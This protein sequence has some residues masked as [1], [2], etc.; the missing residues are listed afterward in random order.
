MTSLSRN[1]FVRAAA[2]SAAVFASIGILRFPADAAEFTLKF[3]C[4]LAPDHPT[5]VGARDVATK[6]RTQTNGR[7][8]IQVF[9]AN[10]L[11]N[12]QQMLSQLRAGAMQL[13]AIGDNI[14]ATLVP[15]AAINN[16]GFTWSNA[17][18]A[19]K[20]LDGDLGAYVRG[21]IERAGLHPMTKVWDEGFREMTSATKPLRGPDD[22]QGFKMR[23]PPSPISTSLFKA[24]GASPT[25]I[26]VK[27]LYSA[28]ETHIVDG[29]ENSLSVI[30]TQKLFEVQK[31]CSLT[32]HM[33][34]AYWIV[35]NPDALGKLPKDLQGIVSA[36]FDDGASKQRVEN[37]REDATLRSKLES[38]GLKFID[39]DRNA[40]RQTL[41]KAG[42][43]KQM[44]EEFGDKPWS[45]LQ[46]YTDV[47]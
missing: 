7:V 22:L 9:P 42:F 27:D 46:K 30:E 17:K 1:S 23:V 29:Q 28:L 31:S 2:G 4:D 6:V 3:G 14:L 39:V 25:T 40:F 24:L 34:V 12:D 33:F 45:L 16:V 43:Y 15:A 41:V 19:F 11:G 44:H 38:Q 37:E 10:Q 18:A 13:M 8:D 35:A 36:A 5:N 20:G 47:G 21:E 26:N 32:D